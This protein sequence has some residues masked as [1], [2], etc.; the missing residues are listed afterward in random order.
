VAY[1][2][3]RVQYGRPIGGFQVIQHYC[4]NMWINVETGKNIL[5][6]V[7]W[8]LGAGLP[9]TLDV[10]AAKGWIN[11]CYKSVT[12]RAVH[13]HGAIGTTRDHDVG[14][15][16]RRAKAAE[17]A[18]GDTDYQREVVAQQVGAS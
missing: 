17:L 15:Y 5:Y 9:A 11:E 10:A 12:E 16:Y 7:A 3:E 4:A 8:K 2:K 18:F 14:L 6:E 1:V 13:C